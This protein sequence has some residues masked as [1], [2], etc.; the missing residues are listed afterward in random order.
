M[1]G[2]SWARWATLLTLALAP[3]L[4][5]QAAGGSTAR[6][7]SPAG[8]TRTV[9]AGLGFTC[10]TRTDRTVVCWGRNDRQQLAAP[11]FTFKQIS[12]GGGFTCGIKS[13]NTVA[14][15]GDA[16][17][18]G[19]FPPAGSF[20]QIS[21]GGLHSCGVRTDG[22]AA[23]WGSNTY[24]ESSPPSGAFTQVAAGVNTSCGIRID[25][26][27]ACWGDTRG[28]PAPPSGRFTQISRGFYHTCAIRMDGALLCW[29]FNNS[30]QVVSPAGT[31][32]QVSAGS[33]NTCAISSAGT[34]ACWGENHFGESTPPSGSFVQVS[35]GFDHTCGVRTDNRVVCW[36]D[37][38]AGEA[39]PPLPTVTIDG[40]PA[41]VYASPTTILSFRGSGGLSPD[42]SLTYQCS[43]DGGPARTCSSP[44]TYTQLSDGFHSLTVRAIGEGGE[45]GPAA[46]RSWQI[47]ATAPIITIASPG[48]GTYLHSDTVTLGYSASDGSGSGVARLSAQLDGGTPAGYSLGSG[49]RIPLLTNLSLG[50]HTF[51]VTAADALGNSGSKSVTFQIIATSASLVLDLQ[52]LE[53][54][55]LVSAPLG[56]GLPT[57]LAL[58]AKQSSAG[59]CRQAVDHD[60]AAI[61]IINGQTGKSIT[62]VAAGILLTDI[63]Y[64]LS[65]CS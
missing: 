56:N 60:R 38:L 41:A 48:A 45:A 11:P 64:V 5:A 65:H 20:A 2:T 26:S 42:A 37:N 36:G 47:D 63:Q 15:W 24:G 10:A 4:L 25:G 6:A 23:C 1:G 17:D 28:E 8:V 52:Q 62:P 43:L 22:T 59:S 30:G 16:G 53:A 19:A 7:Q 49:A 13:D 21:A 51:T 3:T 61:G 44:V 31:F 29:G 54:L 34:V 18:P 46:T 32:N 57:Q 55:G 12:A 27:I 50:S 58:A 33:F 9:S 35:A 14:C 40:P 39:S